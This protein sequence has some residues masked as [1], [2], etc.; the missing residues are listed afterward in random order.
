MFRVAAHPRLHYSPKSPRHHSLIFS[1]SGRRTGSTTEADRLL[2]IVM[3]G[4]AS[5]IRSD[6]ELTEEEENTTLENTLLA[7]RAQGELHDFLSE[8]ESDGTLDP[9]RELSRHIIFLTIPGAPSGESATRKFLELLLN[10]KRVRAGLHPN[11]Q[12]I[13]EDFLHDIYY[14]WQHLKESSESVLRLTLLAELR[15]LLIS[16]PDDRFVRERFIQMLAN[17]EDDPEKRTEV[18]YELDAFCTTN[19]NHAAAGELRAWL[20]SF[21]CT[22]ALKNEDHTHIESTLKELREL[23][24]L[25]LTEEAIRRP[26]AVTLVLVSQQAASS[27]DVARRD[28]FLEELRSLVAEFP[29]DGAFRSALANVLFIAGALGRQ[30]GVPEDHFFDELY[31]LVCAHPDDKALT[32]FFNS[33][34]RASIDP[35][36]VKNH[37]DV[38]AD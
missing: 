6:K 12:A 36:D 37:G 32:E 5:R 1:D 13:R 35:A 8:R 25:H 15:K 10:V 31:S 22:S 27:G 4:Y 18:L 7:E 17:S 29:E 23:F 11:D 19:P 16:F 38:Q 34:F 21:R 26:F 3:R 2:Q 9:I 30:R 33:R 14:L 20:A 24:K 28:V